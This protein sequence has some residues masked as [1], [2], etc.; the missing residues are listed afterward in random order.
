IPGLERFG[1]QVLR[2]ARWPHEPV[3]L[4]GKRVGLIGTGSTG[5]QIVQELGRQPCELFVFQRTPS[6]TMP[7]RNEALEP[8]YMAE[9]RRHYAGIREAARNSAVGGT[10]LQSTRSFFSVTPNQRRMLL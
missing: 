7:M 3:D 6:F 10:R 5:I 1:G 4:T 8:E 2:A 9:V